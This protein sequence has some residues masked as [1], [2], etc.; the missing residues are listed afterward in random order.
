MRDYAKVSPKF[1]TGETGQE[2]ARR[3]SE[4]LVVALYL[5]T[6]PHS[7]MLG[8]FYQPVLY[9]AEESGLSPEG[10]L[11]G[12]QV[13]KEVGFCDY[14]PVAKMVWVY[15]MASYQIAS[16]LSPK[17]LR[18]KGIQKEYTA[19]PNNQFLGAFFDRYGDR[20]NLTDRREYVV[21]G[22]G[23]QP[24]LLSPYEAPT[25]PRA[26][27]EKEKEQE[28]GAGALLV[29]PPKEKSGELDL[30]FVLPDWIPVEPWAGFVEM[31]KKQ[32][33]VMTDR[34]R[35]LKISELRKFLDAG[36]DVG[37]ILD[38]STANCWIDLYEPKGPPAGGDKVNFV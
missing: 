17:D 4:A 29:V 19:L 14:D 31:R 16:E 38:K 33:K 6:S 22:K 9:L 12:L 30:E 37:A 11:K 20:F 34:A 1:W 36:H 35:D 26:G 32:R 21:K 13:C 25:K 24:S 15:E 18:C 8:L 27:T 5:M 2:L 10:A 3:G 7:N 23:H 28:G